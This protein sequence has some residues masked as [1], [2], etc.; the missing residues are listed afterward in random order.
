[1]SVDVLPQPAQ[2][3]APDPQNRAGSV[4]AVFGVPEA[5]FVRKLGSSMLLVMLFSGLP[6]A[7][8]VTGDF[9]QSQ[10]SPINFP[11][12][13]LTSSQAVRILFVMVVF[14]AAITLTGNNIC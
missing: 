2:L 3:A 9:V 1:M 11:R 14:R 10:G 4:A 12:S 8:Q 5:Q 7:F 13:L 6:S